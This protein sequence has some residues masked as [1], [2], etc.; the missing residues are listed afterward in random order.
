MSECLSVLRDTMFHCSV[1]GYAKLDKTKEII[2]DRT[3]PM[4]ESLM[5][6]AE[7]LI[8]NAQ[9]KRAVQVTAPLPP[10]PFPCSVSNHCCLKWSCHAVT[11]ASTYN[12]CANRREV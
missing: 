3:L 12:L 5:T 11:S 1:A 7:E 4:V 8:S 2:Y 6:M 10:P 9:Y